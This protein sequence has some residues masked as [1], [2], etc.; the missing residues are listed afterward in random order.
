MELPEDS[1][2]RQAEPRCAPAL[3]GRAYRAGLPGK[4]APRL[5]MAPVEHPISWE[6]VELRPNPLLH[7]PGSCHDGHYLPPS[8]HPTQF[9]ALKSL[10]TEPGGRD[11]CHGAPGIRQPV[12]RLC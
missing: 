8:Q 1:A 11:G 5:F 7:G 6:W 4:T 2:T 10:F 3:S 9:R 12:G